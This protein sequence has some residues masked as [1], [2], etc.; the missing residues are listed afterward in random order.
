MLHAA[1]GDPLAVSPDDPTDIVVSRERTRRDL[2]L[3]RPLV[4]QY[5]IMVGNMLR[6]RFGDSIS[7][8]RPVSEILAATL[9]R[10]LALMVP[11]L[12]IGVL[13]GALLGTAQGARAGSR[14]DRVASMATLGVVSVPEFLI[15][16]LL[17]GV[18]AVRLRLLPATGMG[19]AAGVSG[20]AAIADY[21]RHAALPVAALAIAVAAVVARF[22]RAAVVDA[23]RE[24]FVTAA[25]ARGVDQ[26]RVIVRHV[27]PRTAPQFY[28]V[29]GLLLPTLVGGAAV[30][31]VVFNWPGAGSTLM[32]AV[33]ARDYPLVVGLVLVGSIA[34]SV[35]SAVADIAAARANP[36]T[37]LR[38]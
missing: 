18:L 8:A 27:L 26:W 6:G 7:H 3:D 35:G 22:Q 37:R 36:A 9:P 31:E 12:L 34:V 33:N 29:I 14:A 32:R 4:V 11:A 2:G 10:T 20:F 30:V 25:R 19:D 16:L 15:A 23:L 28:T 5:P 21:A 38:P 24:D 13:A 17:T 1:P